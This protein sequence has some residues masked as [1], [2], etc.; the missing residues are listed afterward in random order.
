[1]T[2]I[3]LVSGEVVKAEMVRRDD[4]DHFGLYRLPEGRLVDTW[5]DADGR[6]YEDPSPAYD[7]DRVLM[8]AAAGVDY[9]QPWPQLGQWRDAVVA[10]AEASRINAMS[11]EEFRRLTAQLANR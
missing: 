1:M 3:T 9:S 8:L 6:V 2:P 5:E 7:E 10:E 4:S 11:D